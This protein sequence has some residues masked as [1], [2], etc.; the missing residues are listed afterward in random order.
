MNENNFKWLLRVPI[1]SMLEDIH[2]EQLGKIVTLKNYS[3]EEPIITEGEVGNHVYVLRTGAVNVYRKDNEGNEVYLTMLG[4][5]QYFGESVLFSDKDF[6]RSSTVVA[7]SNT[8]CGAIERSYFIS[9]LHS[10]SDV[11]VSILFAFLKEIFN[12]MYEVGQELAFERKSGM[13]Q[14][15]IDKLLS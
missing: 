8:T 10:N 5:H 13:T 3:P 1:F 7:A 9:F 4:E 14:D 15:E 6:P 2:I 11:A 12:R